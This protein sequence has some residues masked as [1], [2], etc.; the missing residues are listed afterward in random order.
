MILANLVSFVVDI[1]P[2]CACAKRSERV[3]V[4]A[5]ARLA[6]GAAAA[7]LLPLWVSASVAVVYSLQPH[8]ARI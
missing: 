3:V 1:P 5:G 6:G 8:K 4:N 7:S 2:P